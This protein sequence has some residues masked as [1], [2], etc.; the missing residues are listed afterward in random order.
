[1]A[2]PEV[3]S[4]KRI[5]AAVFLFSLFCSL[6]IAQQPV[7]DQPSR[8]ELVKMFEVL[9]V[10]QQTE[11]VMNTVVTQMKQQLEQDIQKRYPNLTQESRAKLEASIKDA[12]NLYPVNE[13]LDD[14]IPVYQKHLAK[15]DVEAIIG[16]YSSTAG[17]H[18]LDKMP[19]MTQEAM[20]TMMTKLQVR[21]AEYSENVQRQADELSEPK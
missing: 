3:I 4:M 18:F 2:I 21:S 7:P 9:R 14:L 12:V 11:N 17:Q 10:R 5:L 19:A 15:S 6:A 1:V 8:E 16:F 20:Q 13:M